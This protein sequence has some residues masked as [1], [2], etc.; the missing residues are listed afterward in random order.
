MK[1][2]Q[3]AMNK[4][5]V[6]LYSVSLKISL[7]RVFVRFIRAIQDVVLYFFLENIKLDISNLTTKDPNIN[8]NRSK[9]GFEK[10]KKRL[11][12]SNNTGGINKKDQELLSK[13]IFDLSPKKVLEIGTHTGISLYTAAISLKKNSII[14]TVDL[15]DVNKKEYFTKFKMKYSPKKIINMLKTEVKVNFIQ[16]SGI[17][18]LRST[19]K[20][21]DLIFLDASHRTNKTYEEIIGSINC[22][23][24]NGMILIHDY[25]E[26]NFKQVFWKIF[27]PKLAIYKLSRNNNLFCKRLNSESS[28]GFIHRK[29][30]K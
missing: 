23:N 29:I 22:L 30:K 17:E 3:Y 18:Y 11:T 25:H 13:I 15:Y 19:K 12:Y 24:K 5:K 4:L 7:L 2:I 20:K 14:D 28:I 27:G 1:A 8:S 10:I 16:N 9:K 21:Y 6:I 26:F